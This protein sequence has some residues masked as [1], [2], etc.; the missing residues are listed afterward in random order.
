MILVHLRVTLRNPVD[1][2]GIYRNPD[3]I[4][5]LEGVDN[6][7]GQILWDCPQAGLWTIPQDLPCAIVH[8]LQLRDFV[9]ISIDSQDIYRIPKGNP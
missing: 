7:A 8:A 4:P 5:E 6:R 2:L 9:R 1:I 3:K